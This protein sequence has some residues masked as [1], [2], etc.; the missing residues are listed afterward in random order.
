MEELKKVIPTIRSWPDPLRDEPG[1]QIKKPQD[2]GI[3]SV[4]YVRPEYWRCVANGFRTYMPDYL[5]IIGHSIN[6]TNSNIIRNLIHAVS[7]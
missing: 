4:F 2:A 5:R 6:H 7:V 1:R 3:K